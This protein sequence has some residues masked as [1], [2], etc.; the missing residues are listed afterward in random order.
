MTIFE[1][2]EKLEKSDIFISWKNEKSYLAHAFRMHDEAN[3]DIWQI[4]YFNPDKDTITVFVVD[5]EI[6]QNPD[7]E[8]FKEQEKLVHKLDLKA[9]KVNED[10]ALS[11]AEDLVKEKYSAMT[12]MRSFM[13]LQNL[14]EIGQV[15]NITFLTQQFKS[16]NVKIDS[17]SGKI[18]SHK[19]VSL[20]EK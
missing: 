20:L 15:W 6:T 18:K 11:K 1:V 10:D 19:E 16:I 12:I 7:A 17:S 9:V 2:I 4:G 8:V 13:I 3:K 14:E 5:N